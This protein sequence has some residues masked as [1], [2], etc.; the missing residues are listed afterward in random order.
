MQ[1][2]LSVY[3]YMSDAIHGVASPEGKSD[4]MAVEA[5]A[6]LGKYNRMVDHLQAV[7]GTNSC[8]TA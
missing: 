6:G 2:L 7:A 3:M 1:Y 8:S 4:P 5:L